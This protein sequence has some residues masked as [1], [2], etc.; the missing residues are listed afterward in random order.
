MQRQ[1]DISLAKRELNGWE[2]KVNLRDGLML[3]INYFEELL[4]EK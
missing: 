2:P 3:T 1:P 4:S